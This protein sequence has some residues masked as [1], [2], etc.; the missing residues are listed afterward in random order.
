MKVGEKD[1]FNM[2]LESQLQL[3]KIWCKNNDYREYDELLDDGRAIISDI[4]EIMAEHTEIHFVVCGFGDDKWPVDCR[5]DLSVVIE[6]LPAIIRMLKIGDY[7]FSLDFYEQG[8]EREIEFIDSGAFVTLT[9]CSRTSWIPKPS[10]MKMEK[11]DVSTIFYDL[12]KKFF[13]FSQVLC[14][15]LASN[16]LFLEWMKI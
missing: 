2:K 14:N 13:S 8:I 7:N 11:E 15:E 16:R 9:C 3:D 6:Q 1:M 5:F 10:K 12:Y 4:C